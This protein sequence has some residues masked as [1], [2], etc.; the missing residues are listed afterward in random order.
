[1]RKSTALGA[2]A[3]RVDVG[4]NAELAAFVTTREKRLVRTE[5]QRDV[6]EGRQKDEPDEITRPPGKRERR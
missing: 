2:P 5:P 4:F 1:M 6:D 3:A